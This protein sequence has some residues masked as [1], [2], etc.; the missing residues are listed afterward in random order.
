MISQALRLHETTII[1]HINDYLKKEKLKPNEELNIK[2][3]YLPPY[4]PN[5]NPIKRL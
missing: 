4:N 5:L 3:H 1:R 2:L